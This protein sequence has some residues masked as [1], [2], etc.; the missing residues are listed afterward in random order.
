[1][2]PR[3]GLIT[4]GSR[5]NRPFWQDLIDRLEPELAVEMVGVLDGQ[6]QE[7]ITQNFSF[8]PG[9]NYIVTEMPWGGTVHISEE[10]A[11]GVVTH[12]AGKLFASGVRC[13]LVLCTGDFNRPQDTQGG[14]FLLPE[15][16]LFGLLS[17]LK[18]KQLGFLVPE[19]DQIP[20]SLKQYSALNPII[21][22]ASPYGPMEALAATAAQ[23]R[24]EPVDV[25]VTDCMGFTAEMGQL[26]ARESGKAVL[27]P[28][29][30]LPKLIKALLLQQ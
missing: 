21:K 24:T 22:A 27:V 7:E 29:L 26:V 14:L 8:A 18:Q 2:K 1:M 19:P 25:V 12:L 28:R 9:E 6:T 3:I 10:K 30:V 16:L 20:S 4:M 15:D 13:V 23:F 5:D 17:G 11:K